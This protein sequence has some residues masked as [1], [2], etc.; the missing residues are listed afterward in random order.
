MSFPLTDRLPA[1]SQPPGRA[2]ASSRSSCPV[3]D[4]PQRPAPVVS[5]PPP[6]A[7]PRVIDSSELLAGQHEIWIQ[8]AGEIY[9]L[10]L[11]RNGKLIL[12]K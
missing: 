6:P 5:Q 8:H 3:N 4:D 10:R 9:R 7:T 11:T 1:S 12:Q 2:L